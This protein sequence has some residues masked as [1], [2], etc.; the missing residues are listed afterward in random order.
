[1]KLCAR[2]KVAKELEAFS[3]HPKT[4]DR[5]DSWCKQC[6]KEYAKE[7]KPGADA[8]KQAR[9]LDTLKKDLNNLEPTPAP[10]KET[11]ATLCFHCGTSLLNSDGTITYKSTIVGQ[12]S[13][14]PLSVRACYSCYQKWLQ[15]GSRMERA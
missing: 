13:G 14:I 9:T 7:R 3:N 6:K 8:R 2:C 15:R 1:M 12:E 5:K 11:G 4:K 10:R